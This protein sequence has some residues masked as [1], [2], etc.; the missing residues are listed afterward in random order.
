MDH[1]NVFK[2]KSFLVFL[3]LLGLNQIVYPQAGQ[4]DLTFNTRGYSIEAF[5]G[6]GRSQGSAIQP[7]GKIVVAGDGSHGQTSGFAAVRHNSDGTPDLSFG[8]KGKVIT[9]FGGTSFQRV[10]VA[11][12][13]ASA[14]AVQPDGKIVLAG[15]VR[16]RLEAYG[17]IYLE[18]A[19]VRYN[20]DGSL[21]NTFGA[22]GKVRLR[23]APNGT[24]VATAIAFAPDGKIVVAGYGDGKMLVMRLNIGGALDN[25]F[26]EDGKLFYAAAGVAS[27]IVVQPD[28]KIVVASTRSNGF[29]Y[30]ET[31]RFRIDGAIDTTFNGTGVAP[32]PNVNGQHSPHTLLLQPD[33]K[34]VVAGKWNNYTALMRYNP[35]GSFDN[36]FGT[37]GFAYYSLFGDFDLTRAALLPNGKIVLASS[38]VVGSPAGSTFDF[39]VCRLNSDGSQDVSFNGTSS[40]TTPV[41]KADDRVSGVL[42]QPDGKII[43]TGHTGSGE[44]TSFALVRYLSGGELDQSF[45]SGGKALST[46]GYEN[47][48]VFEIVPLDDGR[49]LAAGDGGLAKFN[50]DG[51][52]DTSFNGTGVVEAVYRRMA[53]AMAVQADGKAVLAGD[54]YNGTYYDTVIFRYNSDGSVDETFGDQGQVVISL[55]DQRQDH[56]TSVA[57][58]PDGKIVAAGYTGTSNPE[59]A[60]IVLFRF[61]FDGSLDNSFGAG[62][63]VISHPC[64]ASVA[65]ASGIALQTDGKIVVSGSCESPIIARF[66][67]DGSLDSSFGNKGAVTVP[68]VEVG[69]V[70]DVKIQNDGR[71]VAAGYSNTTQLRSA[72]LVVRLMQD[73]SA[74]PSFNGDGV[75]IQPLGTGEDWAHSLALQT[76]GK[77]VAAGYG[78]NGDVYEFKIVRFNTDGDLD[79]G[80]WGEKGITSLGFQGDGYAYAAALDTRGRVVAGGYAGGLFGLA[81]FTTDAAPVAFVSV[82][83]R[84]TDSNGNPVSRATVSMTDGNGSIRT[85]QTNAFGYFRFDNVQTGATYTFTVSV[86]RFRFSPQTVMVGGEIT[87]VD[88]VPNG[89]S[90]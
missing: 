6:Y 5:S 48:S 64:S 39:K 56:F 15:Y 47:G 18:I 68:G 8:T 55:G 63:K 76:D 77:I 43:V 80:S 7:D 30:F 78:K 62:G 4:L 36:T 70:S 10:G 58:L 89:V 17:P 73:G 34:I 29:D 67:T 22:D 85:A 52:L 27:A 69:N 16:Y 53:T 49:I 28:G 12:S 83:G 37:D 81:R 11:G 66:N 87:N 25:T 45:G 86:K 3:I 32:I 51:T 71:I 1:M 38:A 65:K 19:I 14:V 82:S 20:Q 44:R 79:K 42:V 57:M 31:V 59:T 88:F 24:D 60:D 33:G 90:K 2:L 26:D 74:D 35:D 61:N 23:T 46:V 9:T 72:F 50:A 13:R 41:G 54:V 40:V 21:D 75:V 84:V